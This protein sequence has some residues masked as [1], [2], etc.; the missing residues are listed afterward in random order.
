MVRMMV[1]YGGGFRLTN[2]QTDHDDQLQITDQ[3]F[4]EK[5][6]SKTFLIRGEGGREQ[7]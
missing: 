5:Q 6:N 4:K 1:R 2:V 7:R 3:D